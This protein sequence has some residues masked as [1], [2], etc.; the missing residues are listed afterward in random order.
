MQGR[1]ARQDRLDQTTPEVEDTGAIHGQHA[2]ANNAPALQDEIPHGGIED[3]KIKRSGGGRPGRS[4]THGQP[5]TGGQR[6]ID[7]ELQG[8]GHYSCL[9]HVA[10]QAAQDDHAAI[11]GADPRLA[12]TR[13][14]RE[15]RADRAGSKVKVSP[16]VQGQFALV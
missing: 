3:A 11:S 16:T 13:R 10:V 9:A 2:R 8:A 5:G 4:G 15:L 6:I 7:A 1:R 14:A 12:E